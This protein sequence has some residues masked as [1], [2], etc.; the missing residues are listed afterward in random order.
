VAHAVR[1]GPDLDL[2]TNNFSDY[3]H[4]WDNLIFESPLVK[5]NSKVLVA[6]GGS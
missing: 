1:I 4:L 3:Y 6:F 2:T 5:V